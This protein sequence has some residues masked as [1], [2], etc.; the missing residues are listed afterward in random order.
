MPI[1]KDVNLT[2]I[3]E[4]TEDYT[5]ADLEAVVREAGLL[6]LRKD[7]KAKEVNNKFF[8]EALKKVRP[9]VSKELIDKYKA[10]EE[11]YL[12]QAKA[13]ITKDIPTYVG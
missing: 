9:S 5:G 3:A 4:K 12:K 11:N 7:I 2:K 13:A 8:E 6:A 1:S 10:V